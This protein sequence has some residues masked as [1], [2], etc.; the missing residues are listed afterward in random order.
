LT[1]T[2]GLGATPPKLTGVEV[3]WP[4]GR[5]ERLPAVAPGTAVTAVEG[6]GIASTMPL[7]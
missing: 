2:F 4:G 5:T 1:L 3:V 7:K 6:K